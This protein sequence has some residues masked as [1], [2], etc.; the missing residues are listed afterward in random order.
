MKDITPKY[1]LKEVVEELNELR[2]VYNSMR[3][4]YKICLAEKER[5]QRQNEILKY[6]IKSK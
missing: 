1:T 6:E 3:D 2:S 5:L 4:E